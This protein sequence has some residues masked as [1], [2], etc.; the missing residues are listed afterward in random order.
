MTALLSACLPLSLF[1]DGPSENI[2]SD[3]TSAL[4]EMNAKVS[5]EDLT[6]LFSD[7]LSQQD[8]RSAF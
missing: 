6:A 7:V 5:R 2:E 8:I 4:S 1:G 3:S